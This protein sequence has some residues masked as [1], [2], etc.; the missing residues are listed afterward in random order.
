MKIPSHFAANITMLFQEVPFLERFRRASEAGFSAVEFQ[1]P[2]E[3]DIR[4]VEHMV[5]EHELEVALFNLHPG[6]TK[7]KEWGT[8][9]NPQ[10]RGHFQWSFSKAME[11]VEILG[12]SRL[13]MM[14]GQ[15]VTRLDPEEQI[16]CAVRNLQWAAPQAAQINVTLLIESLNAYDFPDYFL[17]T[18]RM[19]MEVIRNVNHPN[20]GLQYDV[21]HAQITEG[22]LV[23]TLTKLISEIKHVQ[24]A[25]VP[26]RHQPGTGEIRFQEIFS[27]LE[28]LKYDG[29]VGLEYIPLSTTEEALNWIAEM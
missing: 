19:A 11:I 8:L 21:Y 23:N 25:D 13:N 4:A 22:N 7:L 14:F 20:V 2:Y 5:E 9:S 29:Y 18:T 10:R 28:R 26:G 1:F 3:Y 12:C 16:E 17:T 6:D 15:R 24:I 27:T